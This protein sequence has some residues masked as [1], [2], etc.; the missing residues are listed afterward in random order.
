MAERRLL[1]LDRDGVINYDSDAYIKSVAEWQPLPGSIAAMAR[2]SQAGYTLAVATNQSGL[3]RGYFDVE[4][5]EAMHQQLRTLLAAQGGELARILYCPHAD[6]D[7]CACRKPRPGMLLQLMAELGFSPAQ[8][9]MVGDAVRD[10][11]AAAA[12]GVAYVHVRTGKGERALA[13]GQL[14]AD[15]PVFADLAAYADHVL[16]D[17]A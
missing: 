1:I 11:Q 6:T 4:T 12:A 3:A 5:L 8:T 17:R 15:V 7:Q 16:G 9:V 13:S 14:S 2:L 10:W